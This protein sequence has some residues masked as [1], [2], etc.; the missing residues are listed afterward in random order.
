MGGGE[1]EQKKKKKKRSSSTLPQQ[2]SSTED[3]IDFPDERIPLV[4]V[5]S[6]DS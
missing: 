3:L 6:F 1:G 5:I 2:Y 4:K